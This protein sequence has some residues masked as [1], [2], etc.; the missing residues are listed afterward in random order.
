M[1]DDASECVASFGFLKNNPGWAYGSW[2]LHVQMAERNLYPWIPGLINNH[3]LQGPNTATSP[4][5]LVL[6]VSEGLLKYVRR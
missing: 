3:V 2:I 6:V 5:N 1:R 4:G